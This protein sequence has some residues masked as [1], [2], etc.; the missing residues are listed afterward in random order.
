MIKGV[1]IINVSILNNNSNITSNKICKLIVTL[2]YII[3]AIVIANESIVHNRIWFNNAEAVI[4]LCIISSLFV[5][6]V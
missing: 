1:K 3:E 2:T 6:S 4:T 5:L